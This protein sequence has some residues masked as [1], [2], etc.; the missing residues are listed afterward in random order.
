MKTVK[1]VKI[2]VIRIIV[3]RMIALTFVREKTI[4]DEKNFNSHHYNK[5]IG[6]NYALT[7]YRH[8]L[9]ASP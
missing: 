9:F 2:A 3:T 7:S 1:M 4:S 8:H 6:N 5:S